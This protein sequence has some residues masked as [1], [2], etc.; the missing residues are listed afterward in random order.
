MFHP[1]LS[2]GKPLE[3]KPMKLLPQVFNGISRAARPGT[4]PRNAAG[5]GFLSCSGGPG[6]ETWRAFAF[7]LAAR[8]SGESRKVF[9]FAA[10]WRREE[11]G[12]FTGWPRSLD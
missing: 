7:S 8:G 9:V 6:D 1:S 3:R 4:C 2:A 12:D 11:R 5:L 10:R